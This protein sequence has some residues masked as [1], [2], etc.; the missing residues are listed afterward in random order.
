M[1]KT[2]QSLPELEEFL[3]NFSNKYKIVSEPGGNYLIIFDYLN[4]TDSEF[5]ELASEHFD[6]ML[7]FSSSA[8]RL[9][10]FCI[11]NS[12]KYLFY[13]FHKRHAGKTD[14][15]QTRISELSIFKNI[16]FNITASAKDIAFWQNKNHNSVV[17]RFHNVSDPETITGK[18]IEVFKILES[19]N[20]EPYKL[21]KFQLDSKKNKFLIRW[22]K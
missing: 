15:L 2:I 4:K 13:S 11:D 8:F 9:S 16:F 7:S 3:I 1:G 22:E 20:P 10:R 14:A 18:A 17:A 6:K 19:F 12:E 5:S 21:E